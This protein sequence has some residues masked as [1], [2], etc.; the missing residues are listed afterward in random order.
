MRDDCLLTGR[1]CTVVDS[2]LLL[3]K[4]QALAFVERALQRNWITFD[5]LVRRCH[6]AVG[7]P[8]VPTLVGTIRALGSGARADSERR[9]VAALRRKGVHGW[10]CNL[11]VS[12][13][14]GLIGIV[15]LAFPAFR[16]VIELDGRAWHVDR[17][18]F[19]RDRSRQNRLVAAGWTVL[20]FTWED[21]AYRLSDVLKE[22]N[23]ATA[24]LSSR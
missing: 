23:A 1:A 22:I 19:Q 6:L 17:D 8:G 7:R 11:A 9:L 5:E 24:R 2:A 13:E 20:R 14:R 10:S 12:D 4:P 16:L 21:V 18:R 15:D 3:E